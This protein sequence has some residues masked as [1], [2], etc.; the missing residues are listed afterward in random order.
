MRLFRCRHRKSQ[1]LHIYPDTESRPRDYW[2]R[3]GQ[4]IPAATYTCKLRC[5]CG[6]VWIEDLILTKLE[7]DEVEW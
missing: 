7:M 4:C 3:D 6:A 2:T 1:I 5:Q